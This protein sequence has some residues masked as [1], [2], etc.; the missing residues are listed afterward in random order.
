MLIMRER[1]PGTL[2]RTP[3]LVCAVTF[4]LL[5]IFVGSGVGPMIAA[6]TAIV[7]SGAPKLRRP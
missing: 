5:A 4:G 6:L 2:S 1:Q 3:W 7:G